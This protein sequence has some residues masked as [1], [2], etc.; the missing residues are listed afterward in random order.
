MI[1][2]IF[3][4]TN[5]FM[6]CLILSGVSLVLYSVKQK[7]FALGITG[8]VFLLQTMGIAMRS[9]IGGRAP[10]TNM[11]ETVLTCGY[12]ALFI[13]L[14]FY[15]KKKET[16]VIVSG[17]VLNTLTLIMVN[18]ATGMLDPKIGSLMPVLRSN[19]WLS[20][21]VTTIII[22][23][24]GLA[25][26]WIFANGQMINEFKEKGSDYKK[27]AGWIYTTMKIGVVFLIIGIV[28]GAIWADYSWG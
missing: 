17:V 27:V 21:H 16:P 7:K 6:W 11:Y 5:P 20:V 12:F 19:F 4:K 25:L 24:S 10:V 23:Y 14:Y 13:T 28:T 1:E 3:Y 22:A 8:I 9:Y 15:L 2:T 26:S 18:F